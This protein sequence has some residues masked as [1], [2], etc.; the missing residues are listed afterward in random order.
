MAF[1]YWLLPP[2]PTFAQLGPGPKRRWV[3]GADLASVFR[4]PAPKTLA[5]DLEG[6]PAALKD[7]F[8]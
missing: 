7:P 4:T 3:S 6:M 8:A 2:R 5:E 1:L